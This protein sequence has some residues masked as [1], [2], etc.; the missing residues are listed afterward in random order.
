MIIQIIDVDGV[1]AFDPKRH[2]P[3]A[4]DRHREMTLPAADRECW[5]AQ[6]Y[7]ISDPPERPIE[8]LAG[9]AGK[10]TAAR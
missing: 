10:R 8:G 5:G 1:A 6:V 9:G 7:R 2:P 4:R 3:V